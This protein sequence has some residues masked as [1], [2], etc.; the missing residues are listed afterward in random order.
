MEPNNLHISKS[1]IATV[2][3]VAIKTFIKEFKRQSLKTVTVSIQD[4]PTMHLFKWTL[5][6][7]LLDETNDNT[8]ARGQSQT[9]SHYWNLKESMGQSFDMNAEEIM[10]FG[11]GLYEKEY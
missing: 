3:L 10:R 9:Q 6:Q 7:I 4:M 2:T 8:P 1:L 5:Q 11:H